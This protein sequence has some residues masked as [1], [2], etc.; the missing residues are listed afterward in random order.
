MELCTSRFPTRI[1][2]GAG[3]R[4]MLSEFAA[5]YEIRRPL[6]VTDDGLS[7]TE[8]YRLTAAV[9]DQVWPGSWQPFTGIH[10]NPLEQDIEDAFEA[11]RRAACVVLPSVYRDIYGNETRVPELLGQTLLEGMACECAC[12]ATDVASLREVVEHEVTGLVVPPNDP[13]SLGA[14]IRWMRE[15]PAERRAMRAKVGRRSPTPRW[16]Q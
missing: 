10:P 5:T 14:A 3:A 16:P 7:R 2:Y 12:I 15:H 11:Y 4:R 9:L 6:L 8:A 13:A 1:H